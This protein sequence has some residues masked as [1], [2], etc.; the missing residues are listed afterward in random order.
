M[1]DTKAVRVFGK[2]FS[3]IRNREST[4]RTHA[5]GQCRAFTRV[6]VVVASSLT[7]QETAVLI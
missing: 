5:L 7:N 3:V 6:L 1:S 4:D 2:T